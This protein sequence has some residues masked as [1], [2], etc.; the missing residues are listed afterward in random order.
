MRLLQPR[1]VAAGLRFREVFVLFARI[2]L[3]PAGPRYRFTRM[4]L[5]VHS[6]L[7][8]FSPSGACVGEERRGCCYS[9]RHFLSRTNGD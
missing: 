8:T 2:I 1:A 6:T 5:G 9:C 7:T 3:G 4:R